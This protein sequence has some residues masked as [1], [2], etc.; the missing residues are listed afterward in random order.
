MSCEA[1]FALAGARASKAQAKMLVSRKN[2]PL[3]HLVPGIRTARHHM[4]ETTNQRIPPPPP[5][6]CAAYCSSHFRKAALRVLCCARATN[7]ACSVRQALTTALSF[8]LSAYE[9]GYLDMARR[10]RLPLVTLDRRL[11]AAAGQA[12]IAL[13]P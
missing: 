3:I 9:A 4:S 2:L 12:G 10:E 6:A 8:Q 11:L 7:R 13:V 1:R 5:P